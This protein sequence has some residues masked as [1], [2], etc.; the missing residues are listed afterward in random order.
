MVNTN[1]IPV[2]GTAL[3]ELFIAVTFN[4]MHVHH[5]GTLKCCVSS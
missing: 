3:E 1:N 5:A 2:E 4:N